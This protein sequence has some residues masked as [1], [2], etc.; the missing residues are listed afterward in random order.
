[1]KVRCCVVWNQFGS[2]RGRSEYKK[3]RNE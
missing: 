2:L 3:E 1:L